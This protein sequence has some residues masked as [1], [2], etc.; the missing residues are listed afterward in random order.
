MKDVSFITTE[1]DDDLI[2]AFA[3]PDEDGLSVK[4]LI[5]LRTPKFD[6][7]LH[8][9]ARGVSVSYEGERDDDTGLLREAEVGRATVVI[10]TARRRYRLNV[11]KVDDQE[12]AAA[13]RVLHKMNFDDRFRLTIIPETPPD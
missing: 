8:D 2:V 11:R 4:S 3:I 5:L 12:L 7:I 1:D 13:K 9:A 10:A 6:F